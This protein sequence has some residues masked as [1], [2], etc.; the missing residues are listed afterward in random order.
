M[1]RSLQVRFPAAAQPRPEDLGAAR[2]RVPNRL[3][4]PGKLIGANLHRPT[5]L[6][7]QSLKGWLAAMQ[8]IS[9]DKAARR[10]RALATKQSSF[11]VQVG[12]SAGGGH[13]HDRDSAAPYSLPPS[14]GEILRYVGPWPAADRDNAAVP[15][16]HR[17]Q[18]RRRRADRR[19]PRTAGSHVRATTRGRLPYGRDGLHPPSGRGDRRGGAGPHRPPGLDAAGR[20][21]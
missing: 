11:A 12:V 18:L 9:V 15:R 13:S 20:S 7:A 6:R 21:R 16:L 10:V 14:I 3:P 8:P 5:C 4:Q 2:N 1:S 19:P 17:E